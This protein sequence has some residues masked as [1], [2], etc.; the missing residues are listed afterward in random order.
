MA[1]PENIP[2]ARH[3]T[4]DVT[5]TFAVFWF[6]GITV[7]LGACVAIIMA[8]W[9]ESL[10]N[11]SIRNVMPVPAF[12]Q[13]V[14]QTSDRADM[15]AFLR[16]ELQEL[17]SI[18]WV[19]R[20]AGIVHIPIEEAMQKI[21]AQ[22]IPDWPT[23]A[24]MQGSPTSQTQPQPQPQ[25]SGQASGQASGQGSGEGLKGGQVLAQPHEPTASQGR[26]PVSTQPNEGG[27]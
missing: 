24:E 9:P 21:A 25:G 6:G 14:L 26:T 12:P 16:A 10:N 15:S 13:P 18:G 20:K 1:E 5:F 17:N 11:T 2:Q 19:D 4:R 7:A 27:R 3:E 8:I 22:G 23:Q